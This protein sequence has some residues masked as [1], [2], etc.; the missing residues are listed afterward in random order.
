MKLAVAGLA[1]VLAV[2]GGDRYRDPYSHVS[3]RSLSTSFQREMY[4]LMRTD[5]RSKRVLPRFTVKFLKVL[6]CSFFF[7][8][9]SLST[10]AAKVKTEA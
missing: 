2:A 10:T 5:Q 6:R 9:F 8:F 7:S 4:Q 3:S 1:F